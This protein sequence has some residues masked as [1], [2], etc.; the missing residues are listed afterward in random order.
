VEIKLNNQ[1]LHFLHV[2]SSKLLK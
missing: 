2:H 1:F